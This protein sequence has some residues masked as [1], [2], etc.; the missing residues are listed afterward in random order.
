MREKTVSFGDCD[1]CAAAF[2]SAE[3][4][5]LVAATDTRV[6]L[7]GSVS[8]RVEARPP[9]PPARPEPHPFTLAGR[10]SSPDRPR[11]LL[12]PFLHTINPRTQTISHRY[13]DS[14][15]L[16][17]WL[18]QLLPSLESRGLFAPEG[19]ERPPQGGPPAPPPPPRGLPGGVALPG[20]HRRVLPVFV[21]DVAR[22]ELL[23]LDK[24]HQAVAFPDMA[25][26]GPR[27]RWETTR[28]PNLALTW[29]AARF[30]M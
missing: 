15:E 2:F 28:R 19:G 17:T 1:L 23:L 9:A 24:E 16:H 12:T 18:Q 25:R 29:L 10:L 6:H 14:A 8:E 7:N 4:T 20:G 13:L 22:E 27:S 30:G 21:F 26:T 3:R 5:H 11:F